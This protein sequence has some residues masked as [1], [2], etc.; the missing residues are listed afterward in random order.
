VAR[1][2]TDQ[3][4][5]KLRFDERLRR[6]LER[7]AA[8]ND[9]SMNSEI[10]NRLEQ[11]LAWDQSADA[12]R[13]LL[14]DSKAAI[15]GGLEAALRRDGYQPIRIDQGRIWAEP[16]MNISRMSISVDA[17]AVVSAMEPELA[18]ILARALAKVSK[19]GDQS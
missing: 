5:L 9:R 7:E 15:R 19:K 1:K 10:V 16:G 3:V 2:P 8:R 6:Q 4:Q 14:A 17:A 18:E 12:A 13:K 11:S